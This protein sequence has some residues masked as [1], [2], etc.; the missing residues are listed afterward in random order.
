MEVNFFVLEVNDK[1]PLC[2]SFC[3]RLTYPGQQLTFPGGFAVTN[4]EMK[5][6]E[7]FI[8]QVISLEREYAHE[9]KN[10]RTERR[11]KIIEMVD[12]AVSNR[13]KEPNEAS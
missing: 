2:D 7:A 13:H 3:L 10:A 4:A 11:T 1:V 12:R 6:V 5:P 8:M 9:D